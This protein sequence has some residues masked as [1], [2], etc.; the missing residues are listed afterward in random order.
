ME[1]LVTVIPGSPF[2]LRLHGRLAGAGVVEC[3]RACLRAGRDIV[4]DLS[5]LRS[6]DAAGIVALVQLRA[7]GATL[8]GASPYIRLLLQ[9]LSGAVP[10]PREGG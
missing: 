7:A 9:G 4:L 1:L 2:R 5:E 6:A 8:E 10:E 3:E